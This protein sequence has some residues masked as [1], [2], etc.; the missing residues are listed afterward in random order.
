MPSLADVVREHAPSYLA[1]Y[2]DAMPESHVRALDAITQCRTAALGAEMAVCDQCNTT[3]LVF[4]SCR[5]R[6]CARCGADST[7]TW[8]AR[9]QQAVLPVPYF[10]LVFTLPDELRR[11]VRSHQRILL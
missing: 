1:R 3:H 11:L 2:R 6:A 8:I 9:R 5:H 7:A 10:H 4:H